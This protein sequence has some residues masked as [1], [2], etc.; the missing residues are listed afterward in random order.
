MEPHNFLDPNTG[1]EPTPLCPLVFSYLVLF[2]L[3]YPGQH[4]CSCSELLLL[5]VVLMVIISNICNGQSKGTGNVSVFIHLW[6][7]V[8][9]M[10]YIVQNVLCNVECLMYSAL[11]AEY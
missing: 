5:P 4:T 3:S 10:T 6:N 1:L 9:K 8:C 11:T 7:N 2:P